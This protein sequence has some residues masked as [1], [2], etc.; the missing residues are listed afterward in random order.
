MNCAVLECDGTMVVIDCGVNFPDVDS[1]G[2]DMIIPDFGWLEENAE[3]IAGIVITHGHQDHI[4]GL[5][6]LLSLI[7]VPVWAPRYALELI[8]AS[9]TEHE[10]L[11][12]TEL[13][14]VHSN[15]RLR[16]GPFE[17]EFLH[18]NHSIPD[19]FGLAIHT[20]VGVFVHTGDFKIDDRPFH[21]AP[22]DIARFAELGRQGVRA[23]FSDST[24]IERAGTSGS[25]SDVARA[26]D[27]VVGEHDRAVFLTLFA[28]N[29]FRVQA[30]IEAAERHG[31]FLMVLGRS[32]QRNIE[33][34]RKCGILTITRDRLI[35]DMD[36]ARDIPRKKL[37]VLCTGSQGQPRAALTRMAEGDFPFAIE[38]GDLVVFS[39]RVIPGAEVLISQMK[40]RLVRRGALLL[41]EGA[42]VHCSGHAC[43][44]EQARMIAL[45]RPQA[46]VPVH[47]DYR[48]LHAHAQLGR[49]LGV[50]DTHILDNGDILE[51]TPETSA[52][53][54]RRPAKRVVV[55]SSGP[56]S[57]L[58]GESY[59]ERRR[60][61][62]RG[63]CVVW[64]A[65]DRKTHEIVDGPYV[66]NRG[67]LDDESIAHGVL[68][69]A[70]EAAAQAW[71]SFDKTNNGDTAIVA[72][73]VRRAVM[74]FVKSDS[75]RKPIIEAFLTWV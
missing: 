18:V 35:V 22:F 74:R 28:T 23:L 4:G 10:L 70:G 63:L 8:R 37:V 1:F 55:D 15:K 9:L 66:A 13:H 25:E 60:L 21:D 71:R 44:D 46:L 64:M 58:D 12:D 47:G 73:A 53:V 45:T 19:C 5:P 68:T 52:V 40:D 62:R 50:R 16:L 75:G 36:E 27:R 43:R 42:G 59:R 69:Q 31:R 54:A 29:M 3:R 57:P 72:E 33:S 61:A 32:L 34:A 49:D 6:Y 11:D 39:A 2:I 48:F 56:F 65:V 17:F 38:A 41:A 14:E 51:F 24:N 7:D 26:I 30:A 67:G 20:P